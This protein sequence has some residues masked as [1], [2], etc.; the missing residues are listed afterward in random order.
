MIFSEEC[1]E[2]L[3]PFLS[4][5]I[6]WPN[7]VSLNVAP[8]WHLETRCVFTVVLSDDDRVRRHSAVLFAEIIP[9]ESYL[10]GCAASANLGR[11]NLG[12][13]FRRGKNWH[14]LLPRC[15]RAKT[16]FRFCLNSKDVGLA[17]YQRFYH[18]SELVG[19]EISHLRMRRTLQ[20]LN[21]PKF[22]HATIFLSDY[23]IAGG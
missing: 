11:Y 6:R 21:S 23:L 19:R 13:W 2:L 7:T 14:F 20:Q 18:S 8:T 10:Y 9:T 3:F 1:R 15:L 22:F 17:G 4:H 12:R 16:D 5:L